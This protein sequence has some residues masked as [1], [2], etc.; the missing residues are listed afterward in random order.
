MIVLIRIQ[1]AFTPLP[2]RSQGNIDSIRVFLH[3]YVLFRTGYEVSG[4]L[5]VGSVAPDSFGWVVADGFGWLRMLSGG[6]GWF[7]VVCCFSSYGVTTMFW[8]PISF[9]IL[10]FLVLC[11][12]DQRIHSPQP[13]EF[14]ILHLS[15]C[16]Q[17]HGNKDSLALCQRN[18]HLVEI[19]VDSEI[20]EAESLRYAVNYYQC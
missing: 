20:F 2:I 14:V 5:R 7:R 19:Q 15:S 18:S 8:L 9:N 6:F 12:L 13:S 16:Q 17:E 11:S 10:H 1:N 3:G 4:W